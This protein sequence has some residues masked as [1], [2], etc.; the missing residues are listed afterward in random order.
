MHVEKR[1]C[2]KGCDVENLPATPQGLQL[3][4]Q[5][6]GLT[7]VGNGL[8]L[9][10]DFT[11]LLPRVQPANLSRELLVRAAK[12]KGFDG[13]PHVVDATAGLGEDSFLL[14]AAGFE[15]TLCERDAVIAVLLRDA[16]N[17]AQESPQLAQIA[18]QMHLYEGDS[19]DLLSQPGLMPQV[20]YL[21]P[22]FPQKRKTDALTNKKL[23]LFQQLERPCE[24]EAELMQVAYDAHPLKIVVKRPLKGPYLAEKKPSHSLAGKVV[25][26]DCYVLPRRE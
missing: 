2:E 6:E 9:R 14:A 12:I 25:R 17:R 22:M 26:Y 24:D 5:A 15:V 11:H 3:E 8:A 16:L 7:L 10:G 19:I 13:V 18:G 1:G 20:V 4:Y 21:D 23:Q